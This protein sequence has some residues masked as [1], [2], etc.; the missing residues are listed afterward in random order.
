MPRPYRFSIIIM[1]TSGGDAT[2]AFTGDP[3][4]GSPRQSLN[5]SHKTS[6]SH[7]SCFSSSHA[8]SFPFLP[9]PSSSLLPFSSPSPLSSS[10]LS[11]NFQFL[12]F[13]FHF[14]TYIMHL[15]SHLYISHILAAKQTCSLGLILCATEHS[16]C[17]GGRLE[18]FHLPVF[19]PELSGQSTP[20]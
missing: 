19:P 9:L 16:W 12:F 8:P 11:L 5:T 17:E 18:Q 10:S 13:S 2:A 1:A 14:A 7:L 4:D 6:F 15:K 20:Q 3:E